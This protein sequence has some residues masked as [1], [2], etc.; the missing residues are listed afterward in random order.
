M[1]DSFIKFSAYPQNG[2][3]ELSFNSEE[4]VT[5]LQFVNDYL[6]AEASAYGDALIEGN[7]PEDLLAA[8]IAFTKARQVL[9]FAHQRGVRWLID[10]SPYNSEEEVRDYATD[11]LG[12]VE[13]ERIID[14][15]CHRVKALRAAAGEFGKEVQLDHGMAGATNDVIINA[16]VTNVDGDDL[17]EIIDRLQAVMKDNGA[18]GERAAA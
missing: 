8:A 17:M 3:V 7:I 13:P 11:Y 9:H 6:D 14:L 15:A 2:R 10:S 4:A 12:L 16:L 18:S 5:A 1:N